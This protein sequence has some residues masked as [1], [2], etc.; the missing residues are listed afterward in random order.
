MKKLLILSSLT[1][2][3]GLPNATTYELNAANDN[4]IIES[5]GSNYNVL[6]TIQDIYDETKK[7]PDRPFF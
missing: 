6:S 4:T 5:Y 2:L 1:M 3:I 7:I